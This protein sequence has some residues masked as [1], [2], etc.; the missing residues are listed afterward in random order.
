MNEFKNGVSWFLRFAANPD[1]LGIYF[2][3]GV[4]KCANCKY[5]YNEHGLNR[6]RCRITDEIIYT[7]NLPEL[8]ESCPFEPTGEIRGIKE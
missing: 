3:E 6:C 8:P 5:L 1:K 4:T 7:P 2:P